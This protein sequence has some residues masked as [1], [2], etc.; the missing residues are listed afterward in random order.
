MPASIPQSVLDLSR[1]VLRQAAAQ[2]QPR[3]GTQSPADNAADSLLA[4]T[5]K[6]EA[7]RQ[8]VLTQD[9]QALAAADRAK[10]KRLEDKLL[11]Q[12]QP[13]PAMG[14]DVGDI[15]VCD[16]Y[17]NHA[18]TVRSL[19]IPL[20]VAGLVLA[21]VAIAAWL[22]ADRKPVIVTPVPVA[23]SSVQYERIHERQRPDGSWE[24]ISREPIK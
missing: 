22:L 1:E 7:A 3:K 2:Q 16:D 9:L 5:A 11:F 19:G 4:K 15:I 20:A 18:P 12:G 10:V 23:P 24:V 21:A 8:A 6:L 14:E 17:T 13:G